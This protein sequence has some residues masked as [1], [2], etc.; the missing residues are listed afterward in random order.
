MIMV[1]TQSIFILQEVGKNISDEHL[2]KFLAFLNG[3]LMELNPEYFKI[4]KIS[5]KRHIHLAL[6]PLYWESN[7]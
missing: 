3:I 7:I 2:S 5:K 6:L 4:N 1:S